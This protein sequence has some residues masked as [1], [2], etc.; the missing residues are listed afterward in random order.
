MMKTSPRAFL[1]I[2]ETK[3]FSD[4]GDASSL[5]IRCRGAKLLCGKERC[6]VLVKFYASQKA[7]PM[8]E[9]ISIQG[10]TPPSVFIGRH[11]YPNVAIGPMIPPMQG[12]TSFIDTPET[13]V[14]KSIDDIVDFRM[15]LVR[16]K[17]RTSIHNFSGKVVEFTR[18]V[19]LARKPV[20]MEVLFKKKPT[21]RIAL[22]DE[23]QPHGPSAPIKKV[24]IENPSIEAKI[25]KAFYDTDLKAR[26]AI[27]G[28]Y[29]NG[30]LI[31][32]IQKAFS[33]GAFG[34]EEK[35][36]FVP[37]RWSITAV[38]S[39]IG[40]ELKKKVKEYPFINEYR[41]YHLTSLD[42][43]WLILMY[44]SPWEYELIEAWYPNTTWN[45][46]GK[47]IVI[48]G[49]HEF[50][51][52]RSKYATIGGCYY[53]ARLATAEALEKERRQAGIV[54]LREIHPGYIMPVGVWNVREHVRAALKKEPYLCDTLKEA[55]S[56]ISKFM[57]IPLQRWIETSELM[58]NRLYQRRL[59]DFLHGKGK[60][61]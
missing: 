31:S 30:I 35:R 40:N 19:A 28:L 3:I 38:D 56:Y 39:T 6:P 9:S 4:A 22:Y 2:K 11:G 5:C 59:E 8:V 42:N 12:D 23:V 18:E 48:F 45:P 49:D 16:G 54:V 44:P 52:G 46:T 36:K 60:E 20:D 61:V 15:K 43:K 34:I 13:W 32:Q 50:Y 26:E 10:S 14:G 29:F 33:V 21:G 53:A 57:N 25:E 24:W 51:K 17:Y 58:K 47:K 27:V 55:L 37:T 7:K 1:S 41:I